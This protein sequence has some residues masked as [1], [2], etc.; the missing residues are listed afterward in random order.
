MNDRVV[1]IVGDSEKV[2][3]QLCNDKE[4]EFG[5]IARTSSL[6]LS[7][8]ARICIM[9]SSS[10]YPS[11]PT[12]SLEIPSSFRSDDSMSS[13]DCK[14]EPSALLEGCERGE[15]SVDLYELN[16]SGKETSGAFCRRRTQ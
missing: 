10:S 3:L 16:D 8:S 6:T 11:S 2:E 14:T 4:N 7:R 5:Y 15:E 1:R 13:R 12:I 9:S